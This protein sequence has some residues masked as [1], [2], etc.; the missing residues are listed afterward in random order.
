MVQLY[1]CY[2]YSSQILFPFKLL[3]NI[4]QKKGLLT[5]KNVQCESC[6][7]SFIWDKMRT[8][9]WEMAPQKALRNC[10]EEV[11]VKDTVGM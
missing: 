8:A 3:Q 11:G 7:L 6:E 1:I 9:A 10:S 2:I 4:E 5:K